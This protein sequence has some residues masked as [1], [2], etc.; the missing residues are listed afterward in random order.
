MTNQEGEVNRGSIFG[1]PAGVLGLKHEREVMVQMFKPKMLQE[2]YSLAKLQEAVKQDPAVSTQGWESC[3][4]QES[5][6]FRN[7]PGS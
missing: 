1:N 4:Q 3:L 5:S 7:F 2:D 6:K